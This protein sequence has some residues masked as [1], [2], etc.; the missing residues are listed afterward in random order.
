MLA[1]CI[2]RNNKFQ[3]L[4]NCRVQMIFI[5][6]LDLSENFSY[7]ICGL[8]NITFQPFIYKKCGGESRVSC[9]QLYSSHNVNNAC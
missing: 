4:D 3:E 2:L 8:A 7:S 5:T 9:T 6:F 1:K